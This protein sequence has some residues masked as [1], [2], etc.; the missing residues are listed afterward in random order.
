MT[1]TLD[2]EVA[3]DT[4]PATSTPDRR[5]CG[6]TNSTKGMQTYVSPAVVG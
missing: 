1:H 3:L 2:L 4:K 5:S 6:A